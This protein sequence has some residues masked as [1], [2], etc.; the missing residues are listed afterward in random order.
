MRA[1]WNQ[2]LAD[3]AAAQGITSRDEMEDPLEAALAV[4]GVGEVTGGGG[5]SGVFILDVEVA[6]EEAMEPALAV[7]RGVLQDLKVP[8]STV[9]MRQ[10]PRR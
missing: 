5:G 9:I 7:I 1:R 3:E 10:S 2:T 8:R 4:A 6:S